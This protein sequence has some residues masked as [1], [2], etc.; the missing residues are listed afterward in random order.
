VVEEVVAGIMALLDQVVLVAV[1]DLVAFLQ[2][3]TPILRK[4]RWIILV[5]STRLQ[6]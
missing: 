2:R 1:A 6:S 3:R 4:T 5:G